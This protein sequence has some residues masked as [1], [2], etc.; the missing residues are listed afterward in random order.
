MR[1][2]CGWARAKACGDSHAQLGGVS[3]P[4]TCV[5]LDAA[6]SVE[7]IKLICFD[8]STHALT[9]KDL[10]IHVGECGMGVRCYFS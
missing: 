3:P 2:G 5:V 8:V 1:N 4:R 7:N 9:E 10:Y 6:N